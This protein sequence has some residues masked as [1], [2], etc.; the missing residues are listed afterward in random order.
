[1]N[2][3]QVRGRKKRLRRNKMKLDIEPTALHS[4]LFM[5]INVL[6]DGG[7]KAERDIKEKKAEVCIL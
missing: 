3:Q 2:G 4:T 1:M 6:M 5:V 7:L